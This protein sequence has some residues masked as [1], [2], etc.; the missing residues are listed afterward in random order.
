MNK[1]VPKVSDEMTRLLV[2][3]L[4]ALFKYLQVGKF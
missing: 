2:E 4:M 1:I 3:Q